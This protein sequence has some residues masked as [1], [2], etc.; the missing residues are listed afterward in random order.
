MIDEYSAETTDSNTKENLLPV[1][2][3]DTTID[4]VQDSEQ[5]IIP[6]T[7]NNSTKEPKS[8][9]EKEE[10]TEELPIYEATAAQIEYWHAYGGNVFLQTILREYDL[11]YSSQNV[12]AYNRFK[13]GMDII[14]HVATF[15][16]DD[17][18][19]YAIQF[20]EWNSALVN[21]TQARLVLEKISE[22]RFATSRFEDFCGVPIERFD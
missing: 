9:S 10:S 17:S 3:T 1:A 2:H 6:P 12:H 16:V 14:R 21:E 5:A 15:A 18:H 4:D 20:N 22:I 11:D 13:I 19:Y 8:E 7:G